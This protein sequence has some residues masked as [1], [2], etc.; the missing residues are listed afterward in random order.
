MLVWVVDSDSYIS[1][2]LLDF[3]RED[4]HL[5]SEIFFSLEMIKLDFCGTF[6]LKMF[7]EL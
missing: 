7:P 3:M 2:V 6:F 1:E 4:F 5:W